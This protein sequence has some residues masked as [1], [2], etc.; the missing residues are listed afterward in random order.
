MGKA[1]LLSVFL[2]L[3][4]FVS[5]MAWNVWVGFQNTQTALKANLNLILRDNNLA[6]HA[7]LQGNVQSLRDLSF[8][9]Q[10]PNHMASY[11]EHCATSPDKHCLPGLM[12]SAEQRDGASAPEGLNCGQGEL[13]AQLSNADQETYKIG[14]TKW[15]ASEKTMAPIA[16]TLPEGA[17]WVSAC[18][19]MD[20]IREIWRSLELPQKS[21]MALV[22]ASD[23][24]LWI[25][26]PF[27]PELLGRDLSDGPLVAAMIDQA[28]SVH[29]IADII[30][31]KTDFVARTVEWSPIGVDD[32]VLVAGYPKDHFI[33][34]WIDRE[35]MN[36]V[37]L[38]VLMLSLFGLAG[39]SWVLLQRRFEE[40]QH[41]NNQLENLNA[42]LEHQNVDLETVVSQRTEELATLNQDLRDNLRS[43][44]EKLR[45]AEK[46]R[47]ELVVTM[48]NK[49]QKSADMAQ[50]NAQLVHQLQSNS[51]EMDVLRDQIRYF[52]EMLGQDIKT[53]HD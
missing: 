29:G 53:L 18:F 32:L 46:K 15:M 19:E 9:A 25:R 6:N 52:S 41:L 11:R 37:T 51:E 12:T 47:R 50:F 27:K 4:A 43:L 3:V 21:S 10:D 34:T 33:T 17:G 8:W 5:I 2:G 23:Y 40:I 38:G 26:E 16:H 20:A 36:L 39:L 49:A 1:P 48:S 45:E 35:Q 30:A 42:E 22:R 44:E 24:H 28:P 14:P 31:T 13:L 7:V